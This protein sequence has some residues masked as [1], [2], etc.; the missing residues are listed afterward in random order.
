A[1]GFHT[2]GGSVAAAL[3]DA[4]LAEDHLLIPRWLELLG[5]AVRLLDR[6]LGE[7]CCNP[8]RDPTTRSNAAAALAELL[9]RR[10]IDQAREYLHG[11]LRQQAEDQA[12]EARKD[13]LANRQAAAALTLASLGEPGALWPLLRHQPDPRLRALL[14]Q[15]LAAGALP[16]R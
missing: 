12:P 1:P 4:L 2:L 13:R 11:V 14:I 3:A 5:P 7:I 10:P 16:P 6:P 15:R 9:K 8:D